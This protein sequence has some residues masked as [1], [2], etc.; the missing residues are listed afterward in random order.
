MTPE[1]TDKGRVVYMG[2]KGDAG[3]GGE[4]EV[5]FMVRWADG[6]LEKWRDYYVKEYNDAT[7]TWIIE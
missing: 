2:A 3:N 7:R 5:V 4:G 1:I 6:S